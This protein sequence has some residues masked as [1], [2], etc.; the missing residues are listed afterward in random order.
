MIKEFQKE[1]RWLSNFAPCGVE[2]DGQMYLSVE[3]A[4]QSAKSEDDWDWKEFCT[5][6]TN[7][8]EIKK[9][10][11]L[12][13]LRKDWDAVKENIM[14]DLLRQKFNQ[15][16]YRQ[17]LLDTKNEQIQE[18]NWWGDD[19][20]GMSF[21]TGKGQNRLGKMIMKIRKELKNG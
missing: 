12:V 10:A 14:L 18:G 3:H 7:P 8:A 17:K 2:L 11:K 16:P 5:L 21:K 19:Y 1:Y 20:W 13:I 4:Y 9:Q 15:E 6:E